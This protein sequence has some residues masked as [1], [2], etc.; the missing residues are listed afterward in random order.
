MA[1][2]EWLDISLTLDSIPRHFINFGEPGLVALTGQGLQELGLEKLAVVFG[3]AKEL[4]VHLVAQGMTAE[5]SEDP[6]Q[7][8][9]DRTGSRERAN[10]IDRQAWA[11]ADLG[12][13]RSLIYEAWVGYARLNPERVFG[14]WRP[15]CNLPARERS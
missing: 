12:P 2:T 5:A 11:L 10:D 3:L 14:D 7:R 8:P 6:Y 15:R 9:L 13:G 4:M 1:A